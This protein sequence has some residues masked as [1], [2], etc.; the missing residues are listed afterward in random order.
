MARAGLAR[1]KDV[2]GR[3]GD[4]MRWDGVG[5]DGMKPKPWVEL[6]YL[7]GDERCLSLRGEEGEQGRYR[8]RIVRGRGSKFE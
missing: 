2:R 6:F 8:Y 1:L 3:A 4:G 5:W 7:K